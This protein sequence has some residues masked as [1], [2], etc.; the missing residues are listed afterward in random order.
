M[1]DLWYISPFELRNCSG[2]LPATSSSRLSANIHERLV[3]SKPELQTAYQQILIVPDD[4]QKLR[5]S[6]LSDSL[7]ILWW[8]M[9]W[10]VLGSRPKGRFSRYWAIWILSLR[11]LTIFYL[12][13]NQSW[14]KTQGQ[15]GDPKELY[16][17]SRYHYMQ[18][19][20][21]NYLILSFLPDVKT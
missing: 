21:Q 20:C 4:I 3:F 11:I 16:V 17:S 8:P 5:P 13:A 14:F 9:G 6:L 19:I 10:A 12:C 15:K 7:S 2:S 1:A 18:E